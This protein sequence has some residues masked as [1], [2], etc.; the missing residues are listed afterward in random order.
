MFDPS[1]YRPASL[2][3]L[4]PAGSGPEAPRAAS[5]TTAKVAT[6]TAPDAPAHLARIVARSSDRVGWLRARSRGI[7]ATDVAKLSTP[8]SVR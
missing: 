3:D 8:R 1:L 7:T 4:S 5:V 6:A 2:V